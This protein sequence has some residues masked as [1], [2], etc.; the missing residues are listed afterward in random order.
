VGLVEEI[1]GE[2]KQR[3][4]DSDSNEVHHIFLGTRHKET[5]ENC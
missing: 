3:E 4:K 1:N 2:G 5:A